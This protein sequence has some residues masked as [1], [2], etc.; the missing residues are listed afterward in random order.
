MEHNTLYHRT[1]VHS[2]H[3]ILERGFPEGMVSL[4]MIDVEQEDGNQG[5]VLLQVQTNLSTE[6]LDYYLVYR[7]KGQPH[8]WSIPSAILN[9][10][11]II[12]YVHEIT[13]T[14]E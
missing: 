5:N 14:S 8:S 1:S 4:Y 3:S 12:T 6:E 13:L 9:P 2:A 10:T 11:C 7:G